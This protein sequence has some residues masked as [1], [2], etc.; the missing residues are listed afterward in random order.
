MHGRADGIPPAPSIGIYVHFP[1]CRSRC[2]YCPFAISTDS[3]LEAGYLDQLVAE[4]EA[5]GDGAEAET[6]FFGGGTPSR[7]RPEDLARV[8]SAIRRSYRWNVEEFSIEANPEDIDAR[9]IESWRGLGIDRI[10]I[11]VQSIHDV[12]L[13]SIGRI[14]GGGIALEALRV[15]VASGARVSADLIIGLPQQTPAGFLS[16]LER[17]LDTGLGHLSVYMLDLEEGTPL[18]AQVSKGRTSLPPSDDVAELYERTIDLTRAAGLAQYEVSNF[19]RGGEE[20]RHN[21]GYWSRRR[22]DGYGAGAHSFDGAGRRRGNE[23]DVARYSERMRLGGSAEDL[24]DLLGPNEIRRESIFLSLRRAE[25]IEYSRLR[26]WCGEEAVV[27]KEK[28]LR[29]GLVAESGGRVRLTPAGFL[30]SN[31]LLSQLF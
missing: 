15:A 20:C 12:E 27:W 16:S 31:D 10:S 11:G 5:R 24:I 4:I 23:R 25:G 1:F 6:L 21:I 8:T 13:R 7:T 19:A 28:G 3:A 26:E 30:V 2:T 18:E 9:V 14:H 17:V 29:D 22:Y